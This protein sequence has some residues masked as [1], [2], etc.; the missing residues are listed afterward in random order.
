VLYDDPDDDIRPKRNPIGKQRRGG[1][2][3]KG[4]G[5]E[6]GKVMYVRCTDARVVGAGDG[7]L[8]IEVTLADKDDQVA[9]WWGDDRP[10]AWP[11][12]AP[13]SVQ[14]IADAGGRTGPTTRKA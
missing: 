3:D 5:T 14:P 2:R 11:T 1:G 4:T 10:A 8:E 12:T 9:I 13:A 7:T 6:K